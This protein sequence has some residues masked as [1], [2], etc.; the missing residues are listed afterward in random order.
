MSRYWCVIDCNDC[1]VFFD[2][3]SL[4]IMTF[5]TMCEITLTARG[6]VVGIVRKWCG[7]S[8]RGYLATILAKDFFPAGRS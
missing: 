7:F 8:S 4:Q 6:P 5:P 1:S 2:C 3:R